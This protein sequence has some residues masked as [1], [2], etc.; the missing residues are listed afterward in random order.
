MAAQQHNSIHRSVFVVCVYQ[1]SHE[2]TCVCNVQLAELY[3][4]VTCTGIESQTI[5]LRQV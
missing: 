2:L 4:P 5:P 3:I 1:S